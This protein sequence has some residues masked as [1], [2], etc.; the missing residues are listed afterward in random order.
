MTVAQQKHDIAGD[1]VLV[2]V[3]ALVEAGLKHRALHVA[4]DGPVGRELIAIDAGDRETA[5]GGLIGTRRNRVAGQHGEV[6]AAPGD[7][8]FIGTRRND[9]EG[10]C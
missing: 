9:G 1:A 8:R 3:G 2:V 6:I 7:L 5:A 4:F 10:H